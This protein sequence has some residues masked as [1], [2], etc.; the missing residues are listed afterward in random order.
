ME[1]H[2]AIHLTGLAALAGLN[3][4]MVSRLIPKLESSGLVR[5]IVEPTDHRVCRLDVTVKGQRLLSRIRSER[6]DALSVLLQ[7]LDPG[8]RASLNAAVSILEE[9]ADGLINRASGTSGVGG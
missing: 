6:N 7:R 5:R 4:T 2:G 8:A 3:P 9:L 1:K